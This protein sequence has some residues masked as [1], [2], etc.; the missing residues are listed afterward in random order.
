MSEKK[1][2]ANWC[3]YM[4]ENRFNG[5]KYIGITGQKPEKRWLNGKGYK[6]C[7]LFYRAI[8]K[9]GWGT[10]KHEILY[11]DLTEV[12]AERL[13][14]DLIAKYQTADLEHGYNLAA[15]GKTN[16]GFHRTDE[17]KAKLSRSRKGVYAGE[18]HVFYGT[19]RS[20]ETKNKIRDAQIGKPK[21]KATCL[22]MSESAKRRWSAK[23]ATEQREHFR[24]M[25]SG[26]NSAV[27]KCV[28]CTETG[29]M[30]PTI[31]EAA[32]SL[33]I[34]ETTISRCCRGQRKTAGGWHWE[35]A[36]VSKDA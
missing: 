30:Y 5:K 6:R 29:M 13:E 22:K 12:E 9:Y 1:I 21:N 19:H 33:G 34:D 23:N 24:Q 27:A 18:N 32:R 4:H 14:A 16:S 36:E 26:G 17:F 35:Y 15:G 11:T 31:R 3:V 2:A 10:F 25:Y 8:C 28:M 20:E 7:P